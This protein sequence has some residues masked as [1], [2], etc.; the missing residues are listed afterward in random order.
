MDAQMFTGPQAYERFMGRWSR[1]LAAQLIEFLGLRNAE[2]VLDVG[3]GTGALSAAILALHPDAVVTGIDPSA[4]FVDHARASLPSATVRIGSAMKLPFPV[5]SFDSSVACLVLNF[6]DDPDLA[7]A[8]MCA[9]TKP[10]GRVAAAVWDH[11]GGMM[12][13]RLFWETAD[14]VDP[15]EKPHEPQGLL[16]R[17]ALIRLWTKAGL[18][19]IETGNLK[20]GMPFESF[21]DYWQPFLLGQGPAG[22]Y[23][24]TLSPAV[25]EEIA[26]YLR[27]KLLGDKRDGSFTLEARAWAI[28]GDVPEKD[29]GLR[30][31]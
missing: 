19:R 4:P 24:R 1:L 21:D 13:L 5:N 26:N 28:R 18:Q 29:G 20:I 11:A 25:R 7:L 2:H 22:A 10:G 14:A 17:G 31:V 9:V 8:Q 30:G 16:D 12:M 15:S 23:V 27:R 6:V 3:C